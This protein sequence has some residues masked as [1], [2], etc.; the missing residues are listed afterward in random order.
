M[1]VSAR[2]GDASGRGKDV[3]A[4]FPLRANVPDIDG[5]V[6]L[7]LRGAFPELAHRDRTAGLRWGPLGTAGDRDT[8]D[9]ACAPREVPAEETT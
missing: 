7:A 4:A 3:D 8:A 6:A 5:Y 1:S 9:L 2:T